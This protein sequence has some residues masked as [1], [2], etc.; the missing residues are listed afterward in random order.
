LDTSLTEAR[1]L[2]FA[3]QRALP[4]DDPVYTLMAAGQKL[5]ALE[6]WDFG[7]RAFK[8]VVSFQPDY[9]EAWAYLGEALQHQEDP[10]LEVAR[11][12]LEW[13]HTLDPGSL[14]ANTFMALYWGRNGDPDLAYRYLLTAS[15]I[16]PGNPDLLVDLGA[17]A[18]LAG[19]LEGAEGY[20]LKAIRLSFNDL[21][22]LHHYVEFCVRYNLD[23]SGVALPVARWVLAADPADPAALDLMGQVLFRLGDLLS[24]QRFF[25]RALGQDHGYAPAHLH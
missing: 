14:S 7:L 6:M 21:E 17:A 24:A 11:T 5:A 3:I 9:A 18:A 20:Y 13:A 19:D 2:A 12:A 1:E 15:E 22:V 23:L 4:Q 10:P 16:D 25:L 8:R